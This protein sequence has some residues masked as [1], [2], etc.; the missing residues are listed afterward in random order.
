MAAK[1]ER[2]LASTTRDAVIGPAIVALGFRRFRCD[3]SAHR[4]PSTGHYVKRAYNLLEGQL[5]SEWVTSFERGG[6]G[7]LE[8]C[9]S[10]Q[11]GSDFTSCPGLPGMP[12]GRTPSRRCGRSYQA[13]AITRD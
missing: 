12:L 13:S 4:Q 9:A 3:V 8:S 6:A 1:Q 7:R 2:R 11:F 10:S 5:W